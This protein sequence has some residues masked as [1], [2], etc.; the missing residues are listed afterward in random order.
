MVNIM[1][2]IFTTFFVLLVVF[3]FHAPL[4]A[5]LR[6]AQP[7]DS[8]SFSNLFKGGPVSHFVVVG[9]GANKRYILSTP[10]AGIHVSL[11][12][13]TT[14]R[15]ITDTISPS[16]SGGLISVH[17]LD[18]RYMMMATGNMNDLS[19]AGW[20]VMVS[21]DGGA[22]WTLQRITSN[23]SGIQTRAFPFNEGSSVSGF[24]SIVPHPTNLNQWFCTSPI[25]TLQ[26]SNN[27][28]VTS[29]TGKTFIQSNLNGNTYSNTMFEP[30]NPSIQYFWGRSTMRR[31]TSG[32]SLPVLG[33]KTYNAIS[34]T[35]SPR[36]PQTVYMLGISGGSPDQRECFV[37]RSPS[38]GDSASW[39]LQ[40]T[41]STEV[42]TDIVRLA[43][44]NGREINRYTIHSVPE[45]ATV[46]FIQLNSRILRS[47]NSGQTWSVIADLNSSNPTTKLPGLIN[48]MTVVSS[49]E[50][51]C[52]TQ[53]GVMKTIDGGLTWV[54]ITNQANIQVVQFVKTNYQIDKQDIRVYGNGITGVLDG[55][56]EWKLD[57]Q[58]EMTTRLVDLKNPKFVYALRTDGRIYRSEDGGAT[59]NLD[60]SP[61]KEGGNAKFYAIEY[62]EESG[63]LFCGSTKLYRSFDNG[64]SWAQESSS[65]GERILKIVTGYGIK[66][67]VH[68]QTPTRVIVS[69]D[70]GQTI[71]GTPLFSGL[72]TDM[73]INKN[74]SNT[75]FRIHPQ[76]QQYGAVQSLVSLN[77][78]I[79][80]GNGFQ[81]N[82]PLRS[83]SVYTD[84]CGVST[85]VATEYGLYYMGL[86]IN[87]TDLP[88]SWQR[89]YSDSPLPPHG[90]TSV[91]TR[92]DSILF[93]VEGRGVFYAKHQNPAPITRFTQSA[94]ETCPGQTIQFVNTSLNTRGNSLWNFEGG[95]PDVG[96]DPVIS[97]QYNSTGSFNVSLQ[98]TSPSESCP[99]DTLTKKAVNVP[100]QPRSAF[101]S[102][103]TEI[104]TGETINFTMT[105]TGV[106]VK[107]WSVTGGV[108]V[109]GAGTPSISVK[110]DTEGNFTINL[111]V[112]NLC[113][114]ATSQNTSIKVW[115]SL[116]KPSILNTDNTLTLATPNS[117]VQTYQ[118]FLNK[119]AIN[120]ATSSSYKAVNNGS[121]S[122]RIT[123]GICSAIS[124]EVVVVVS[125][126]DDNSLIEAGISVSPTIVH[127]ALR[128]GIASALS[129][130]KI[131]VR[132]VDLQGKNVY[133]NE[134]IPTTK[135]LLINTQR[136]TTGTYIVIIDIN[137]K[138]NSMKI[139][140]E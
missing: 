27:I 82:L 64:A 16:F 102:S 67:A 41:I 63:T 139:I 57:Q 137:G 138:T 113:G 140:K 92:T 8:T 97:V 39:I 76:P 94:T 56:G 106:S 83:G 17:P 70:R 18:S 127:D 110:Y 53:Q 28:Y 109:A 134:S 132:V 87:K 24:T 125:S 103:K 69:S 35:A 81:N 43:T 126:V 80:T 50:L 116:A 107:Q 135:E 61:S 129:D 74:I 112:S 4:T 100:G 99:L 21:S 25:S 59:F 90:I 7:I 23:V 20:G 5:Q 19:V 15:A 123:N 33:S 108:V 66:E 119:Q 45:N 31:N 29:D 128:I 98:V 9:T 37:F 101:T 11:D 14:W 72:F 68:L 62:D 84:K 51:Y 86:D 48:S 44:T 42:A 78:F 104:C 52:S 121:Y 77:K 38:R 47:D 2:R 46:L 60:I 34:L 55:N 49:S 117:D 54:N 133:E 122:V 79:P 114:S 91:L 73:I 89:L 12:T 111:E 22:S 118:W 36:V 6:K 120:G 105:S 10:N 124:D 136:W 130:S 32:F 88:S 65:V 75:I 13:G 26:T 93:T 58:F 115:K 96:F 3:V 95:I 71:E 131:G 40:S 85:Y 30:N 1:S